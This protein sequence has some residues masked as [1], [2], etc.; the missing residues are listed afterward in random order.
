MVTK[1]RKA[2]LYTVDKSSHLYYPR[3]WRRLICRFPIPCHLWKYWC[4]ST[5]KHKILFF[6]WSRR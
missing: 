4:N 3:L 5:P 6:F 2:E 1:L